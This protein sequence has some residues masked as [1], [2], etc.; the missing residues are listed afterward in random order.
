M[1]KL[2]QLIIE[3]NYSKE[4]YDITSFGN[5]P[6]EVHKRVMFDVI[7]LN[8]TIIQIK[9]ED[10]IVFHNDKGFFRGEIK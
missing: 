1:G 9:F 10:Q 6:R 2:Y 8:E 7:S 3:N 5:D 4:K